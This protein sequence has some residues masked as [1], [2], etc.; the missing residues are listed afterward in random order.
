M[1]WFSDVQE[2]LRVLAPKLI[3]FSFVINSPSSSCGYTPL[4]L[5]LLFNGIW[6]LNQFNWVGTEDS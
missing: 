4:A 3:F 6:E 5:E 2:V 1:G